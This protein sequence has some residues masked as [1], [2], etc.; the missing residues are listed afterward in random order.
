MIKRV[1]RPFWKYNV[2]ATENW[3]AGMAMA[4]FLLQS[5]DYRRRLFIFAEGEPQK[6]IYRIDYSE[7][8]KEITPT[9]ER[10]GWREISSRKGWFVLSNA[11]PKPALFPPR[12]GVIAK[13]RT[14]LNL[15]YTLL[16]LAAA[17]I[18]LAA[19]P[20]I[21]DIV[22]NRLDSN[23][24]VERIPAPHPIL[25]LVPYAAMTFGILFLTWIIFTFVRTR[26]GL[27][28]LSAR[29]GYTL[30]PSLIKVANP[31]LQAP[32]NSKNLVKMIRWFWSYSPGRLSAWLEHQASR[33][34]LLKR[35]HK[36]SFYFKKGPPRTI[37]YFID[38]HKNIAP[39]YF[40]I[41]TQAGF[42]LVADLPQQFGRIFIWSKEQAGN[43]VVHGLYIDREEQLTHAKRFLS[44]NFKRASFVLGMGAFY[45]LLGWWALRSLKGF[46]LLQIIW[47]PLIL[48]WVLRIAEHLY[49]LYL[50]VITYRREKK[51]LST[52]N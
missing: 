26:M 7:A 8:E 14:L 6:L 33:G 38:A 12:E 3:L 16:L 51:N 17:Y 1:F 18:M 21:V 42:T 23:Y 32:A 40:D 43:T 35:V 15:S 48:L 49:A 34:M 41:H 46:P 39:G 36:N 27:T 13:T 19:M 37:K 52:C 28:G 44:I 50:S 10:E 11:N 29:A 2:V 4:G 47:A 31:L 30:Y 25:E 20:F 9:L 5:V 22:L 45:L 24:V